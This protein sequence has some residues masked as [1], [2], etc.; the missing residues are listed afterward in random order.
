MGSQV[1]IFQN[2]VKTSK[3]IE[4]DFYFSQNPDSWPFFDSTTLQEC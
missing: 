3:Q 2:K 1:Q 4:L